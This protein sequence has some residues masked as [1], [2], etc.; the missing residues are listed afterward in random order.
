MTLLDIVHA[1]LQ[2]RT[3]NPK[4]SELPITIFLPGYLGKAL[5]LKCEFSQHYDNC[6]MDSIENNGENQIL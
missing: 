1:S 5:F 3:Q 2:N 6:V 4:I